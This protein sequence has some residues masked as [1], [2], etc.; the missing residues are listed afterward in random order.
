MDLSE[1]RL[2]L[3]WIARLQPGCWRAEQG[4]ELAMDWP[5]TG[6]CLCPDG[7]LGKH[8]L[9]AR[10]VV[11]QTKGPYSNL[12]PK[13]CSA[14]LPANYM[15]NADSNLQ[16]QFARRLLGTNG[17]RR[18]CY[19]RLITWSE[20]IRQGISFRCYRTIT[21]GVCTMVSPNR[22]SNIVAT[23]ASSRVRPD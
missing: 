16:T 2:F 10:D 11:T 8:R 15:H 12:V 21:K 18:K 6:R 20:E 9:P 1:E 22:Q 19:S 14:L 4:V 17:K 3:N 23:Q 7:F 5:R 13:L